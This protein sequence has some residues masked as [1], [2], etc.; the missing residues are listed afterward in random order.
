MKPTSYLIIVS[1]LLT[2]SQPAVSE[3]Q[4]AV[5]LNAAKPQ[6][7]VVTAV[8]ETTPTKMD[9][10]NDPAIWVN[11]NDLTKS[12]ILG[13][14]SANGIEIYSLDGQRV[15]EMTDRAISLVDVIYDFPVADNHTDLVVAYDTGKAELVVYTLDA[16]TSSL[17]AAMPTPVE[18]KTEI[19][20][21]C[22][23]RSPL[24]GKFYAFAAGGGQIQQWE[25]Y[26]NNG[27][28]AARHTRTMP[29]G[30]GAAHCVVDSASS[31]LFYTQET[32]G[33]WALSAE[34][35]TDAEATPIELAQPFGRIAG[36]VKG[37]ALVRFADGGYLIISDADESLVHAYDLNNMS[38]A[39]TM[40]IAGNDNIDG[41]DEAEGM[42]AVGLS[43]SDSFPGGLLVV[44]DDDNDGEHTNYKLVSWGDIAASAGLS[45]GIAHD[46]TIALPPTAV[47]VMPSLETDPVSSF[48]DAA[49]DP[50]IWIHPTTPELSLVL[51]TQKQQGMNVYDMN[52]KTLQSLPDGR[53]N[54]VDIRYGFPL[55]GKFVDIAAASN[56][57]HDSISIY[58]I[59]PVSRKVSNLADGTIDT[60][61][62]DPYGFCM[63]HNPK[64]GNFYVFV[65]DTDG[66]V[67]Q[68]LLKDAG[69]GRVAADL[70]RRFKIETQTEG[71]VADDYTAALYIGE[72]DVG[73]WK[74]SA[75]PESGDHRVMVDSTTDGNLTD[76]VEGL[77][78][79]LGPDGKGYLVAS[80]QGADNYAI[81]DRDGD[82]VFRGIFH[83]VADDE[84]GIDG[85][86]ETDGLE[87]TSAN[88]GPAFP[89]GMLVVQDGRNIMPAERQN[90]KYI[91]WERIAEAL[92]LEVYSGYDPRANT[93]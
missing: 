43:L 75:N 41:V 11:A 53:L 6:T 1:M 59:D 60:G 13:S 42:T 47:V 65:N 26:G 86:S 81:Y 92:D 89:N 9:G 7:H 21:L 63:Y 85:S 82:N 28:I 27:Q 55:G 54:N 22:T 5:Q 38:F 71:C 67:K 70:V 16:A 4:N 91:P 49:D 46:P 77:A 78:L 73:I 79:Y 58:G 37:I 36:D 19:E 50:A 10:A 39:A 87:V 3:S 51:G 76:D 12:L 62:I 29:V 64:T 35:E 45:T 68:W 18:L 69:N 31:T 33:V 83:V 93:Q 48:G 66:V 74:Y 61:M 2:A 84:T 14:A 30:L 88:L 23:Y 25:L 90:F 8:A 57:T 17:V 32:I 24:T 72:E 20:G 56:R 15:G 34:P 44:N 40:A 52:G 80:N